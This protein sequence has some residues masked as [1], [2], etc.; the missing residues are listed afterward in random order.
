MDPKIWIRIHPKMSWIRNTMELRT[1][2]RFRI[3]SIGGFQFGRDADKLPVLFY[4]KACRFGIG[5]AMAVP[6]KFRGM[7]SER[8]LITAILNQLPY[9]RNFIFVKFFY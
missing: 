1:K 9:F 6:K 8:V 4:I 7:D 2:V 3:I 5:L